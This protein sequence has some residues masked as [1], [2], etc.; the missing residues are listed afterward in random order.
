MPHKY[1]KRI[2]SIFGSALKQAIIPALGLL[3]SLLITKKF[4]V[5]LWGGLTQISIWVSILIH[6]ASWGNTNYLMKLFSTEPGKLRT[7]WQKCF[8][9]RLP[10]FILLCG[11]VA[12]YLHN[13]LA[14]LIIAWCVVDYVYQSYE[15]LINFHKRFLVTVWAE[16]IGTLVLFLLIYLYRDNLTLPLLVSFCIVSDFVKMCMV[17]I[18][19]LKDSFPL[20]I[21]FP[22]FTYY[23]SAFS[24]F[25]LGFVGLL[26]SRADLI[27]V[28]SYLNK[29]E[30][31][32]Y[33][34][35]TTFFSFI[36]SG[37]NMLIL[38]FVPLLYRLN[39]TTIYKL[40]LRF[41]GIG[42]PVTA[43]ALTAVY[44]FVTRVYGF[45]VSF[46]FMCW[47]FLSIISVF[48]IYSIAIYLFKMHK[49]N[50]VVLYS[51]IGIVTN[52]ILCA[53]LVPAQ[54]ALGAIMSASIAQ[55]MVVPL[56][57]YEMGR[58]TT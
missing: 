53:V 43:T 22:H 4:S 9:D 29:Q 17:T 32:F 26:H 13:T 11:F 8:V 30:I 35:I 25:L 37:A 21:V 39:K 12:I 6:I 16:I 55:I 31:A 27:Y 36:T 18:V 33:Q 54:G 19:F 3:F 52:V 40:S 34:I 44:F 14:E 38:P 5:A 45:L 28:M 58:I 24:F 15:P 7:A 2:L 41:T 57:L 42:I 51:V 20:K 56:Y 49:Q 10:L 46:P 1:Q 47:G 50:K 48:Y 23:K